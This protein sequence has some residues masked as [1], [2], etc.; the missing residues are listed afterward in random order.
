MNFRGLGWGGAL[1]V[2]LLPVVS[3]FELA[4]T[5]RGNDPLTLSGAL[6][7]NPV[8]GTQGARLEDDVVFATVRPNGLPHEPNPVLA[9]TVHARLYLHRWE[10]PMKATVD[11]REL[12]ITDEGGAPN[13]EQLDVTD[14][15]LKLKSINPQAQALIIERASWQPAYPPGM[16]FELA[17]T[18]PTCSIWDPEPTEK[19]KFPE[20]SRQV[21]RTALVERNPGQQQLVAECDAQSVTSKVPYRVSLYGLDLL[22][23]SPQTSRTI[24]TGTFEEEVLREPSINGAGDGADR[25]VLASATKTVTQVL[26]ILYVGDPLEVT[27]PFDTRLRL[28]AHEFL[29]AG[30]LN[31]PASEGKLIWGEATAD[32]PIES[33]QATGEFQIKWGFDRFMGLRGNTLN[34][35]KI[36]SLATIPS[37]VNPVT[38]AS[39]VAAVGLL[40]LAARLLWPLFSKL[41]PDRILEHPRRSQILDFVRNQPGVETNTVARSLGL[42]WANVVHHVGTLQRSGH[43]AVHRIGGRTALF[44]ANMGYRGKEEK[45]AIL[46]RDT[47]R[48]LHEALQAHPGMDQAGLAS[49]LQITQQRVSQS[50]RVLGSVALVRTEQ[51][52]RRRRYFAETVAS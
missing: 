34:G 13:L 47:A 40:A 9:K 36:A 31:V 25:L 27:F 6:T 30:E 2:L 5:L 42:R 33:F 16:E 7:V 46:R 18:V 50:L 8:D 48:R 21:S 11:S 1:L 29:G 38:V 41:A 3:G 26:E 45:I 28:Y 35:P 51:D 12:S 37:K 22:L 20:D 32:G 19:L 44:P 14:A 43:I 52:G 17:G 49:R 10:T 4:G 39:G 15:T 24:K 23:T